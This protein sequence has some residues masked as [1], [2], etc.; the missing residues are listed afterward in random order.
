MTT[1]TQ[2]YERWLYVTTGPSHKVKEVPQTGD[3]DPRTRTQTPLQ[4]ASPSDHS[5]FP[6]SPHPLKPI[7]RF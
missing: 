3:D 6:R 5:D 4:V 1:D 7:H 2:Y